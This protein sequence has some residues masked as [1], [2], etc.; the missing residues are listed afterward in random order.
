MSLK[1]K[2]PRTPHLPW[3]PGYTG[4]D[5]RCMD[6]SVFTG[7]EVIVTEKMDGENTSL[8]RDANHA[9]SLDS[10]HHPSRDWIKTFHGA[11]AYQIPV[12]WRI[13]GENLYAKHSIGY[14]ALQSY[15]YGFSVWNEENFCLDWKQTLE[16][17]DLLNI[18]APKVLYQGLWDEKQLKKLKVDTECMEGYV[19]R[20]AGAFHYRE[21]SASVAKWVRHHHVSTDKHW[22]HSEVIANG[23]ARSE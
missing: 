8:Y 13:C 18:V 4:D 11:M 14:D 7:K 6:V 2:Y 19:V 12:G 5:V 21:F 10:A 23:L 22:M 15:F 3:S 1:F 20:L 16:W 17:F 9:R